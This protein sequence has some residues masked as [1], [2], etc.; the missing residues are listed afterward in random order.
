MK[1]LRV[2]LRPA[3]TV[4]LLA[5]VILGIAYPLT[6]TLASQALFGSKANGTLVF[7]DGKEVGSRILGQQFSDSK[8]FKG[9]PFFGERSY[10]DVSGSSNLA[11]TSVRLREEVTTLVKLYRTENGLAADVSVPV[12]AVTESASGRDPHISVANA[13]L[14][15]PRVAKERGLTIATVKKLIDEHTDGR[16]V[17][18]LGEKGVNVVSLN[19]ALDVM[20]E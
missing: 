11:S 2:Q 17:G 12:D 20:G 16:S 19:T 8:Y 10:D 7:K 3:I 4:V 18:F 14:Q 15:A 5:T 1:Q 6:V 13:L 9:R